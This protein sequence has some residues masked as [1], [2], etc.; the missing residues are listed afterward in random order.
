[1]K[2]I[3][4]NKKYIYVNG[5]SISEGGG[6]EPYEYRTDVRDSYS[7]E[8]PSTQLECSYPYFLY[9][10][11]QS[12]QN[13]ELINE[14]KCGSGIERMVR[15]S[16]EWIG[17]S[18]DKIKDTLFIFEPQFGIRID[19]YVNEWQDFG[20]LNSSKYMKGKYPFTLVKRWFY[21]DDKKQK[22]WNEKYKEIIHS[23][24][25][26]F[27]NADVQQQKDCNLLIL[28]LCYLNQLNLDYFITI[29]TSTPDNTKKILREVT[30]KHKNLEYCFGTDLW[31]YCRVNK[32]L[33]LNETKINDIHIGFYGNKKVGNLLFKYI[34][35]CANN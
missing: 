32:M 27:F 21:D 1:M 22:K 29:P 18:G 23:Y 26:N 24:M 30:P 14:A 7:I 19:W 5:T 31:N 15:K 4:L 25:N 9:K 20:I 28:F 13:I 35:S 16:M 3:L 2:N 12:N 6:F 17:K 34:S 11:I 33:I 8:L 10:E